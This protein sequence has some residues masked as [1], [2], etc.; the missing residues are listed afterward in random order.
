MN[1]L[2]QAFRCFEQGDLLS[3]LRQASLL[4]KQDPHN[5]AALNL[6][7]IIKLRN[8]E[9]ELAI[10]YFSFAL[11][12]ASDKQT[13]MNLALAYIQAEKFSQA[14]PLLQRVI[15][16]TPQDSN[17]LNAL[18][19]I[20]RI[21]GDYLKASKYLKR[22]YGLAPKNPQV[23]ENI[24]WLLLAQGQYTDALSRFKALLKSFP[25]NIQIKLGLAKALLRVNK[26]DE[27]FE[28]LKVL[29]QRN[30]ENSEVVNTLGVLYSLQHHTSLAKIQFEKV[31]HLS[32]EH[33]EALFNLGCIFEQEGDANQATMLYAKVISISPLFFDAYFH[34]SLVNRQKQNAETLV[35]WETLWTENQFNTK[36]YMLAFALGRSYE[37]NKQYRDSFKWFTKGR[38]Q[39]S[40]LGNYNFEEQNALVEQLMAKDSSSKLGE[41]NITHQYIFIVGMPR[42]GTTLTEQILASHQDIAAIGESGIVKKMA[43]AVEQIT[44]K[45][46]YQGVDLLSKKEHLSILALLGSSHQHTDKKVI[47]DSSPMNLH[48]IDFV[49]TLLPQAKFI[50]CQR[51]PIDTCLSIFQHPL[52]KYHS[53]ANNLI[54]LADF[55]KQT[56]RLLNHFI[57]NDPQRVLSLHYENLVTHPIQQI[58]ALLSALG[59]SIDKNCFHPEKNKRIV[60]T[61]SANQVNK[62]ITPSRMKRWQNFK[63]ELQPLIDKLYD[64]ERQHYSKL[65]G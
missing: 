12:H 39:L 11:E 7:G 25:R 6:I 63:L 58:E 38:E 48:Y 31:V 37:L 56:D 8:G 4:L 33:S 62:K 18:G 24:A 9:V 29:A 59:L 23:F 49:L 64:L 45:P 36:S 5:I 32:P 34:L 35:Q 17:A 1:L 40:K 51:S 14:T 65:E 46:F 27:A 50:V 42:S 16:L 3:A 28:I 54:D 47:V 26:Y 10:N 57:K 60:R 19:N 61:P 13:L 53:Y 2:N 44:E 15:E 52:N 21:K 30:P 41:V 22:A 43:D 55:F 20:Y